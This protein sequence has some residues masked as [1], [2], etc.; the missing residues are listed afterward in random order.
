MRGSNEVMLRRTSLS[1]CSRYL[2][3]ISAT[4]LYLDIMNSPVFLHSDFY[5]IFFGKQEKKLNI[6]KTKGINSFLHCE[7]QSYAKAKDD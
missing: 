2:R 7:V 5:F 1:R 6:Q 4:S 3:T